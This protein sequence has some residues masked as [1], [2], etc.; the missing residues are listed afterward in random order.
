[1]G[2]S[3]LDNHCKRSFWRKYVAWRGSESRSSETNKG[4]MALIQGL[5]AGEHYGMERRYWALCPV[6][7]Q[8]LII[9]KMLLGL[10][11]KLI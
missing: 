1:M 5:N 4:I 3:W 7:E 9:Y 10:V 2:T 8:G 11:M 6:H